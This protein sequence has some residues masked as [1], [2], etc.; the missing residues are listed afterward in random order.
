MGYF[1]LYHSIIWFIEN[2]LS[3]KNKSTKDIYETM[4]YYGY[5]G[6]FYDFV[7]RIHINEMSKKAIENITKSANL[8]VKSSLKFCKEK[9]GFMES[10]SF[11]KLGIVVIT[12]LV[13]ITL[14]VVVFQKKDEDKIIELTNTLAAALNEGD[15][16]KMITCF[17]PSAQNKINAISNIGSSIIG[18]GDLSAYWSLGAL[19][20]SKREKVYINIYD[21]AVDKNTA[22]EKISFSVDEG[23]NNAIGTVNLIKINRKWYFKE[24]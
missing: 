5:S 4:V 1:C 15:Y 17:E 9:S 7:D 16:Q 14:T 3:K 12:L 18:Y 19:E 2:F 6:T 21:I 10:L 23:K 22:S 13:F 11:K 20:M 8:L 24:F